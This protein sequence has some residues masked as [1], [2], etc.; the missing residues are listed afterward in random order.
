MTEHVPDRK[1]LHLPASTSF[2][3][4]HT[5]AAGLLFGRSAI[6]GFPPKIRKTV[7]TEQ[8]HKSRGA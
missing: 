4:P 3:P 6:T 2:H 5:V 1:S 8:R 7:T